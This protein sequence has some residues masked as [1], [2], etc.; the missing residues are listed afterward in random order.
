MWGNKVHTGMHFLNI[1][2]LSSVD[3]PKFS[4]ISINNGELYIAAQFDHHLYLLCTLMSEHSFVL[5]T[6]EIQKLFPVIA[7]HVLQSH[8]YIV[9][10]IC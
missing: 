6:Q 5:C 9:A 8:L 4:L 2:R 1:G 10:L 7:N 3:N